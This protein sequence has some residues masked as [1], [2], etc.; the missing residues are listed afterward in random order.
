VWG[1][2]ALKVDLSMLSALQVVEQ[3]PVATTQ[4]AS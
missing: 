1:L 2:E 3:S 4:V